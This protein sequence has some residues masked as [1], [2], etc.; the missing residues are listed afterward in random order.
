MLDAG[1]ERRREAGDET[2]SGCCAVARRNR[3][4]RREE[5]T[6]T[7]DETD[8]GRLHLLEQKCV[9]DLGHG[10]ECNQSVCKNPEH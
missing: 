1:A 9:L 4:D 5:S 6:T 8:H 3:E 10:L 7:V 2:R